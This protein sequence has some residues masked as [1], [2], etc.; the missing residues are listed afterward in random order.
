MSHENDILCKQIEDDEFEEI[1]PE[2]L[3][4]LEDR[5]AEVNKKMIN[6]V[7]YSESLNKIKF[8]MLSYLQC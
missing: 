7:Q 6:D 8:Q 1:I 4:K 3:K 2:K 5:V